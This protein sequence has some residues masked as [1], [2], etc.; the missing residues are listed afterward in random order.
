MRLWPN[1]LETLGI[2]VDEQKKH[3]EDVKRKAS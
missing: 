2:I 3:S 1:L